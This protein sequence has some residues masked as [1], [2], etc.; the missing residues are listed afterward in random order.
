MKKLIVSLF[1]LALI[2][3]T[4]SLAQEAPPPQ[5]APRTP[6]HRQALAEKEAVQERE[7]AGPAMVIDTEHLR[8]GDVEVKLFGVIP[9]QL[10]ASYGPQAR[11]ALD[12]T[13]AGKTV[14]CQIHDRDHDG[15]LMAV[16]KADNVDLA[17]TLLQ[18]GLAVTSRAALLN[19]EYAQ[20]YIAAEQAAAGTKLGLWSGI[21]QAPIPVPVAAAAPTPAPQP[22]PT[23]APAKIDRIENIPPPPPAAVFKEEKPVP[24][25]VKI[26]KPAAKI[27]ETREVRETR[28]E[29]IAAAVPLT[30]ITAAA[31]K[32]SFASDVAA[33]APNFIAQYQILIACF[34]MLI[35]AFGIML[36]LH[37][38]RSKERREEMRAL[39][40]ALRGELMAARAVCQARLRSILTEAD[41]RNATWPRIRAT[42]YQAY[43]GRLGSLGAELARQIASIYGQTSDYS[44]YYASAEDHATMPKRQALETLMQHIEAVLPRLGS[45]E[46]TGTPLRNGL[47]FAAPSPVVTVAHQQAPQQ[48]IE[49][50][51]ART[52]AV[53]E[54]APVTEA[55]APAEQPAQQQAV[56]QPLAEEPAIGSATATDKHYNRA[57]SPI[58][59]WKAMRNFTREKFAAEAQSRRAR[60]PMEDQMPD[61][62]TM[63]DE[64][65][66][67]MSFSDNDDED[68]PA[69]PITKFGA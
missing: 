8:I 67:D 42:L 16:C 66:A 39:A 34:L 50:P 54:T 53:A 44:A 13:T 5:K 25:P 10:S 31:P 43:V 57:A 28:K 4:P 7:V 15:H 17:L 40:A 22:A 35:T 65:L 24:A 51:S 59:L 20:P 33:Q 55:A 37:I 48:R 11:G 9:P 63:L 6:V 56:E 23:P 68:D 58:P 3:S 69:A 29:P 49:A 52:A 41:D 46:E 38:G 21:I 1:A 19:T 36:A 61:Y 32:T 2:A 60:D 64:E 14:D 47:S 27:E 18:R 26:E 12:Q 30:I 45:I 62:A